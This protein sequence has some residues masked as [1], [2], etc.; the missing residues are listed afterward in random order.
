MPLPTLTWA[1][2]A[3]HTNSTG[4]TALGTITTLKTALDAATKWTVSGS[5]LASSPY[6]IEV[7]P[8]VGGDANVTPCRILFAIST[9]ADLS[10][11]GGATFNTGVT[12]FVDWTSNAIAPASNLVAGIA[13]NGGLAT[14]N[15]A[16]DK[17]K[18]RQTGSLTLGGINPYDGTAACRWSGYAE[19]TADT[20]DP[21]ANRDINQIYIVESDEILCVVLKNLAAPYWWAFT[22]GAMYAPP[23]DAD[24]ESGTGNRLWG[25]ASSGSNLTG[26]VK[27]TSS[28]DPGSWP[29]AGST[30]SGRTATNGVFDP[31]SVGTKTIRRLKPVEMLETSASPNL[32][33]AGGTI[34]HLSQGFR[35]DTASSNYVGTMRQIRKGQEA[36]DR[37]VV[38]NAAGADK[39]YL[40]AA[41]TTGADSTAFD[42]G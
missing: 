21:G 42:N 22:A 41:S 23:T 17:I 13:P 25:M 28:S 6:W 35:Y 14:F 3:L 9:G 29:N 18:N 10:C 1:Q 34:V 5:N 20:D 16:A 24:G 38:Q 8:N 15:T 19:T 7:K 11:G 27:A 39:A 26:G 2:G 30:K 32:V 33:T 12:P 40:V 4:A 36:A 37:T 31:T